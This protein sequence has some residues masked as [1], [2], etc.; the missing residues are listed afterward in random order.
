MGTFAVGGTSVLIKTLLASK[1]QLSVES[2]D[3]AQP[4]SAAIQKFSGA[5]FRGLPITEG[6]E[7][8]GIVTIRDVMKHLASRGGEGMTSA[9]SEAMTRD[10]VTVSPS[11]DVEAAQKAFGGRFNHLPVVEDGKLVAVLTPSDLL[12]ER[13]GDVKALATELEHYILGR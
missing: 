11:D 7:L 2:L 1:E 10:P 5:R 6:G 9:I 8:V 13:L 4:V 12:E 3:A